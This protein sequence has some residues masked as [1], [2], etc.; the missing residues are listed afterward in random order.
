[1]DHGNNNTDNVLVATASSHIT[2]N[3][4]TNSEPTVVPTSTYK[5]KKNKS[6]L[7]VTNDNGN[8]FTTIDIK[9]KCQSL[10]HTRVLLM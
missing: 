1:M 8:D 2:P 6:P 9:N 10:V 5:L 3:V 7:I 4:Q